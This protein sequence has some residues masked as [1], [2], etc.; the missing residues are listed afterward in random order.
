MAVV[1]NAN[2]LPRE[3]RI[4]ESSKKTANAQTFG[5]DKKPA[6]WE[7]FLA[8]MEQVVPR[9]ELYVILAP[10]YIKGQEKTFSGRTG[11]DASNPFP[12]KLLSLSDPTTEEALCDRVVQITHAR[13]N[14]MRSKKDTGNGFGCQGPAVGCRIIS[15]SEV[16]KHL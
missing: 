5:K 8:E 7:K 11:V 4:D 2:P 3:P 12:A 14:C 10:F 6:K 13:I 9:K 15:C 1:S 16:P